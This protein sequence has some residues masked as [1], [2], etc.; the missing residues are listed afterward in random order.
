MKY[1][2]MAGGKGTRL[3]PLS[4]ENY[5][6]QFLKL[7]SNKTL[8]E[9]TLLRLPYDNESEI[10]IVTN[11]EFK[12][13]VVD[14]LN[15]IFERDE[16]NKD[17]YD[18]YKY[19]NRNNVFNKDYDK[20]K[21]K[22]LSEPEGKNTAPAIAYSI[23]FLNKD[24]IVAV[25]PSDHYIGDI[26]IFHER[27]KEAE[28]TANENYFVTFGIIPY[29]PETGYGYIEIQGDLNNRG[30]IVFDVKM[31]KEKPD[32]E[33]A[34]KYI[35]EK[36]YF[37]NSGMFV[38]KVSTILNELEMYA[39]DIY[40][41]YK[42]I[43]DLDINK[44]I[45]SIELKNIYN[46]FR[47]IS[48]DYAICEYSKNIKLIKG[49][50]EWTDIGSFDALFDYYKKHQ[51]KLYINS[52]QF[53]ETDTK[54]YILNDNKKN[55]IIG[56]DKFYSIIGIEDII[57]IDTEDVTIVSKKGESK[58]V[59][60]LI[61][62]IEKINPVNA[63]FHIT[64]KRPWG[65]YSNIYEKEKGFKV[66]RI[67]VKPGQKLSLQLHHKREEHWI[68]VQGEGIVQIDNDKM[69][70]KKGDHI[71]IDVEQKHRIECTSK[72]PLIFIEVQIGD[73]LGEDDIERFEDIY[74]RV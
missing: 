28:K 4:R 67:S 41:N 20:N 32:L 38:F 3:F 66:K 17:N 55:F 37:W 69:K 49:D 45:D 8:L 73:Y 68:I 2:I 44:K 12:F 39:K 52:N 48:I 63:N 16:I 58:K 65:I 36:R 64:V 34:K 7:F 62:L 43:V 6:K 74:G 60:E 72:E 10:L 18:F 53:Y 42:K 57:L 47:N 1:I 59:K 21:I 13:Y 61:P 54:E 9:E 24:D 25:L 14:I 51:R 31:F 22:I 35:S 19:F 27:L 33:T 11:K 46:N 56:T 29:Y 71:F 40:D 50:F 70:V 15:S 23:S 30:K 26:E 5:P